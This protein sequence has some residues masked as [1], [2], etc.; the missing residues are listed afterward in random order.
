MFSYKHDE[1]ASV[2]WVELIFLSWTYLLWL[3]IYNMDY[4][5]SD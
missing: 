2:F 4:A 1:F 3:L 5:D